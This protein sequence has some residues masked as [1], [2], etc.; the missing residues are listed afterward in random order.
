MFKCQMCS[1]ATNSR[2]KFEGH[3]KNHSVYSDSEDEDA[4]LF[5]NLPSDE[6]VDLENDVIFNLRF[7]MSK[8]REKS[9]IMIG[10]LNAMTKDYKA[11]WLS[12]KSDLETI[13]SCHNQMSQSHAC[14]CCSPSQSSA[15]SCN[16]PKK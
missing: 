16:N 11:K 9:I 8:E 14:K 5:L 1:F 7:A 10:I 15:D 13:T 6:I 2:R 4:E 12:S 3:I